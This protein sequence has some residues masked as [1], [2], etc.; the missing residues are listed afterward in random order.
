MT[1]PRHPG[2]DA[3]AQM[4][5]QLGDAPELQSD[6]HK[7]R[8]KKK[9]RTDVQIR[10]E[11]ARI[12]PFTAVATA[13]AA[14][15]ADDEV[16]H[17]RHQVAQ[18]SSEMAGLSGQI[19]RDDFDA[20]L[21]CSII[22]TLIKRTQ[23]AARVYLNYSGIDWVGDEDLL[24]SSDCRHLMSG[25]PEIRSYEPGFHLLELLAA[26]YELQKELQAEPPWDAGVNYWLERVQTRLNTVAAINFAFQLTRPTIAA[27]VGAFRGQLDSGDKGGDAV[28]KWSEAD[29]ARWREL[30]RAELENERAARC[31]PIAA[32]IAE[33]FR[34]ET[35]RTVPESTVR[36]AIKD[37]FPKIGRGRPI[38][39]D[40][41][42]VKGK[43]D[44]KTKKTKALRTRK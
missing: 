14:L 27:G 37:L 35:T 43:A 16:D 23:K 20:L 2:G 32:K 39:S 29:K 21:H 26:L 8:G 1:K 36:E 44:K 15:A 31:T 41:V 38:K 6:R 3:L 17:L 40:A 12:E 28:R 19:S 24:S 10:R 34:G 5:G 42:S 22:T 25:P 4:V 30:A 7:P 13:L 18:E 33:T 9:G 11:L